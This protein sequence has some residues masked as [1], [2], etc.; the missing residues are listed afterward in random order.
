[1]PRVKAMAQQR[2]RERVDNQIEVELSRSVSLEEIKSMISVEMQECYS[3]YDVSE[4][5][6]AFIRGEVEEMATRLMDEATVVA[7]ISGSST[8]TPK[9]VKIAQRMLFR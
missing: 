9:H 4:D 2:I 3:G 8:I 7:N 5:A 1:M 6:T